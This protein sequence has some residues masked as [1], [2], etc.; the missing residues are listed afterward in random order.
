VEEIVGPGGFKHRALASATDEEKRSGIRSSLDLMWRTGT[1]RFADF[2][3]EGVKGVANFREAAE[4]SPVR[5]LVLGRP[6]AASCDDG[7][8][9][10]LLG[11]CDGLAFSSISD[12]PS[13]L[14]ERASRLCVSSGKVFAIHASESRREDVDA[15]LALSPSFLVHM[16]SAFDADLI[17]CSEAGVPIVVC[18]RSNEAFGLAPDIPKLLGLGVDVAIGTDNA[19]M[20]APNMFSEMRAAIRLSMRGGG[21][22]P[23]D[24]VHLATYSGHKVLY[25]KG[26][27]TTELSTSDDLVVIEV[28]GEDPLLELVYSCGASDVSAVIRDGRIRRTGD[29]IA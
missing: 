3:E 9:R 11:Q 2:R 12:W 19:M 14:L 25:P 20:C 5:G 21:L 13:D 10:D 8:M 18:P 23:A 28:Q 15:I 26:K 22:S 16:T 1:S 4:G 27:I 29:W 6:S 24:A 17:A 7:E